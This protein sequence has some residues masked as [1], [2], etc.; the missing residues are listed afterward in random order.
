MGKW[1][2]IIS[3]K[4]KWLKTWAG[5]G[6]DLTNNKIKADTKRKQSAL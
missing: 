6:W 4:Y 1:T 2:Q 5:G 3:R